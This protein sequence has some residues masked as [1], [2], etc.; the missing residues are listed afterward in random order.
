MQQTEELLNI[1]C[2]IQTRALETDCANGNYMLRF[3]DIFFA[4][5]RREMP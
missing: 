1:K 4:A 3:V 2:P 5:K